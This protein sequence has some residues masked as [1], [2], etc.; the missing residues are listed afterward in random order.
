MYDNSCIKTIPNCHYF[1][2][3]CVLLATGK[4]HISINRHPLIGDW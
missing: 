4:G 1:V 2:K 3:R